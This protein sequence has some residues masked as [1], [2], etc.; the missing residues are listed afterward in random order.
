MAK[1]ICTLVRGAVESR[2]T[3]HDTPDG[4]VLA[5]FH[6]G[7]VYRPTDVAE[8]WFV[9]L[10]QSPESPEHDALLKRARAAGWSVVV[11]V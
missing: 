2:G 9:R 8:E 6:G 3:L 7:K 11:A 5:P 4:P 1:L 10:D